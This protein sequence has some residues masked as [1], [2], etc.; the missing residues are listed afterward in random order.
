LAGTGRGFGFGTHRAPGKISARGARVGVQTISTG[1]F[2]SAMNPARSFSVRIMA[3]ECH[4]QK[5]LATFFS[6]Q[7]FCGRKYNAVSGRHY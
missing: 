6:T 1:H 7:N 4:R 2:G 5:P 3:A